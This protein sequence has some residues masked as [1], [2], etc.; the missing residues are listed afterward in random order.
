MYITS[1]KKELFNEDGFV[2]IRNLFSKEEIAK[3]S[4]KAHNDLQLDK[5]ARS[6]DDG[7][8]NAVRLSLWNHPG[9]GIYGM[10]A[11]C[12][13]MVESVEKLLGGEVYHYH[14]KMVL[15]EA[16]VGGAWVWHQDYGYWYQNGLLF[17]DLC[18]VYINI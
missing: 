16:K 18:S 1:K 7:N 17:P 12:N 8:G 4:E 14:S 13:K 15:K 5:A 2:I 9:D 3:L 10:F 11:R 6:V